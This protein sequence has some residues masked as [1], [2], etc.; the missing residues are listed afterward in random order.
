MLDIT[1]PRKIFARDCDMTMTQFGL[2]PKAIVHVGVDSDSTVD[3]SNGLIKSQ[4]ISLREIIQPTIS[5]DDPNS[6]RITS[7][8]DFAS[9]ESKE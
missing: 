5:S 9:T 2:V 6:S 8:D 4:Y 3:T 7:K 1:P